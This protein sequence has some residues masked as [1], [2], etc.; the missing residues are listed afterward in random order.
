MLSAA[1]HNIALPLQVCRLLTI[2]TAQLTP[3]DQHHSMLGTY[4]FEPLL[5]EH[6]PQLVLCQLLRQHSSALSPHIGLMFLPCL[7]IYAFLICMLRA[8]LHADRLTSS[9][10]LGF[11]LE[12]CLV[13]VGALA[14]KPRSG[15]FCSSGKP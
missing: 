11:G 10:T 8:R 5:L 2:A 7:R 9:Q 3:G 4:R 13:S 6:P 14:L 1:T 12:G 15:H